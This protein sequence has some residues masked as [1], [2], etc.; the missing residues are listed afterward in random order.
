MPS[1]DR[2]RINFEDNCRIFKYVV[3][4]PFFRAH[5]SHE[6]VFNNGMMAS[7]SLRGQSVVGEILPC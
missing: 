4:I 5:F 6:N 2:S 1:P 3:Q 7:C